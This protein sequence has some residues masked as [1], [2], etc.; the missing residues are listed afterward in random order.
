MRVGPYTIH[1]AEVVVSVSFLWYLFIFYFFHYRI[2]WIS[3]NYCCVTFSGATWTN[4]YSSCIG[5]S[6]RPE[7]QFHLGIA[8]WMG[9]VWTQGQLCGPEVHP[10]MVMSHENCNPGLPAQLAGCSPSW[11]VS[12][13]GSCS[14]LCHLGER[15][16]SPVSFRNF[17]GFVSHLLTWPCALFTSRVL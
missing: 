11:R 6:C 2:Y 16:V 9:E 13:P 8:K 5:H 10:S 3:C 14:S 4:I 17:L 12:S 1:P 15:P 7:K